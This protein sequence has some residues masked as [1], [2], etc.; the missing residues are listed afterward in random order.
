L[1]YPANGERNKFD[2]RFNDPNCMR[3]IQ[4]STK[5]DSIQ[6]WI[7]NDVLRPGYMTNVCEISILCSQ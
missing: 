4:K 6:D 7:T 5:Q 1:V 2:L 3:C